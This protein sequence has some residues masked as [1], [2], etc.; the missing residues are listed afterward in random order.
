M[1][2]GVVMSNSNDS[3]NN[4][5]THFRNSIWEAKGN[6]RQLF[7]VTLGLMGKLKSNPWPETTSAE[8]LANDFAQFFLDKIETIRKDL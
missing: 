6:T 1:H 7:S 4:K 2:K 5:I 8:V 3:N